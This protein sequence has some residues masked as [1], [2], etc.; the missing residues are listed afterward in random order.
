[1]STDTITNIDID[2]WTQINS[3][4]QG[5][6]IQSLGKTSSTINVICATL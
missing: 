2:V 3:M 4:V 1:M 6:N 5:N